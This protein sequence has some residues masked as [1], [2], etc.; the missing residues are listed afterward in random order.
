MASQQ[1]MPNESL[2]EMLDQLRPFEAGKKT[3]RKPPKLRRKP[4]AMRLI[5]SLPWKRKRSFD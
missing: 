2:K 3:F 4:V 5:P 1:G